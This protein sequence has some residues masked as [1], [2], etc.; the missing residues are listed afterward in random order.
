MQTYVH[1]RT[2]RA[3]K[4]TGTQITTG[5]GEDGRPF[6]NYAILYKNDKGKTCSFDM[7]NSEELHSRDVGRDFFDSNRPEAGKMLVEEDGEYF[8]QA[9]KHFLEEFRLAEGT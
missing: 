3:V 9:E 4:I 7:K 8:C 5:V 1:T 2:V 6:T